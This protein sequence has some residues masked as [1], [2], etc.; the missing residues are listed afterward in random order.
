MQI[1]PAALSFDSQSKELVLQTPLRS[2]FN[3]ITIDVMVSLSFARS[4]Y[5]GFN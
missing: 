1:L 2:Y 5:L 4:S 3:A